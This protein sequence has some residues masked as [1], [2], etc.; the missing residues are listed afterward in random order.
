MDLTWYR[1]STKKEV[2]PYYH[3]A[4]ITSLKCFIYY[5]HPLP[6][7][8]VA[9]IHISASLKIQYVTLRS[10]FDDHAILS[11]TKNTKARAYNGIINAFLINSGISNTIFSL[12]ISIRTANLDLKHLKLTFSKNSKVYIGTS[13][14][15]KAITVVGI[16]INH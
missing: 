2:S 4:G 5:Q 16:A 8:L 9:Q 13:N 3:T 7:T 11:L 1:K 15:N 6:S 10:A 12:Y 14:T